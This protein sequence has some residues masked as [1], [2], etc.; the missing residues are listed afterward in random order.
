ML[1]Y[2]VKARYKVESIREIFHIG[3]GP[4]SSHSIGPRLAADLFRQRYPDASRYRVTLYGSL[5][6]TGKG[7]MTDL[8]IN[9]TLLPGLVEIVW[10]PDEVLPLHPNGMMFEAFSEDGKSQDSW[11]V[12][13][14]GGGTLKD[15][16]GYI[17]YP[18]I[19]TLDSMSAIQLYCSQRG[20]S[21]WEYIEQVESSSIWE[22][23][24]QVWDVMCAA[25]ERGIHTEGVLPGGLGVSRK[26]W[27]FFRKYKISGDNFITEGRLPAYALAVAEESASGG[28]IVTAPTC[29]S[30]GVVPAVLRYIKENIDCHTDAVL[31]ALATA[32]LIGN[33]IKSNA[34]ISGAEVGCQGEIGAAC[35][36]AAGA[37]TQLLGGTIRQVEYAAEMGLEHHLGLTCDPVEGLVQIPCIE[38]NVFAASRAI[39]C[40]N[41]ALFSDG[42]HRVSFDGVVEVMHQTGH[43]LPSLYRETSTGGLAKSYLFRPTSGS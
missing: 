15:E 11:K 27:A 19:Y 21:F 32:G 29:G 40:A 12:Y 14:I 17:K 20:L 28:R 33:L 4:S 43:D 35:S 41:F 22:Y 26:A 10:K 5:A 6:A 13:S 36:M 30:S 2:S 9:S 25:I 18:Q 31:R 23:L 37:A 38:R 7:H 3:N 8:A 34:S 39:S 16:D 42:T 24:E 1:K